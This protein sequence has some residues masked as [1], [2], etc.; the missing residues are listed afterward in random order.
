VVS[1]RENVK[2]VYFTEAPATTGVFI[3]L[4]IPRSLKN[5]IRYL[6]PSPTSTAYLEPLFHSKAT[7][8]FPPT[9]K[10]DISLL[11]TLPERLDNVKGDLDEEFKESH[12][13]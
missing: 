1:D 7:Q 13:Q 2:R 5:S 11:Q 9:A 12:T 10:Q 6:A 8:I 4:N 3:Y